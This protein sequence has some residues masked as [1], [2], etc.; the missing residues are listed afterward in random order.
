MC[1]PVKLANTT[2]TALVLAFLAAAR[3]A[4][5][6]DAQSVGMGNTGTAYISN[7]AAIYF[8]PALLQQTG[9]FEG[10]LAIAPVVAVLQSPV[11]APNVEAT[12]ST[13]VAPLFLGG[14]NYRLSDRFVVGWATY[15]TAGFGATYPKVLN[16]QDLSLSAASIETSPSVSF[17]ILRN[18]SV[19]VGY[20]VTYTALQ[21]KTPVF[22]QS[23]SQS[24]SGFNFLGVQAGVFYQPVPALRLGLAYRSKISTDLSGTTT[25]TGS[26]E[27]L[28]TTTTLAWPHMFRAGA[29]LSLLHDSLLIAADVSYAMFSD[30]TQAL[31]IT[32]QPSS[33][34]PTTQTSPLDWIDSYGVGLGVQYL[35]HP[36]VPV[37]IGYS[38][39]RSNTGDQ[40][41]SYFF[42]PPGFVQ[43]FHAGVGLRLERWDFDLGAYYESAAVNVQT[44]TIANTGRYSIQGV[45]TSLSATF[46][47][48]REKRP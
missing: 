45:A 21:T 29:A 28:P 42:A 19:G 16:G 48:G 24:V 17:A 4:S 30:S 9:K 6:L 2:C 26:S 41:A 13:S 8:N 18:L 1:S 25:V 33:G 46:H 11:T 43:T 31:V 27:S 34:A 38:A 7:G 35:V 14:W 36:M 37:R 5:A 32:T 3:S 22:N 12:S 20:R 15:P 39:G 47:I 10:T 23:E 44:D 40:A